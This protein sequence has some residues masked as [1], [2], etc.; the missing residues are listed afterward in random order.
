M[1]HSLF[2]HLGLL[3]DPNFLPPNLCADLRTEILTADGEPASVRSGQYAL[4]DEDIR[5][6]RMA[7]IAKETRLKVRHYLD[8]LL[9]KLESHFNV[10]LAGFEKPNFLMYSEGCFFKQHRDSA[11]DPHAEAFMQERKISV[12]IF[13]NNETEAPSPNSY[14]GGN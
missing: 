14:G 13:L 6:V 7:D 2:A 4:I 10:R 8:E 3:T 9:P 1:N 11:D 12:V 5:R